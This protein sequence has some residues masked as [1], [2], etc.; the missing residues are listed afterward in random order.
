MFPRYYSH[1]AG[2]T[3]SLHLSP[4]LWEGGHGHPLL[5]PEFV[6]WLSA[7]SSCCSSMAMLPLRLHNDEQR[8]TRNL[9]G[10]MGGSC[11]AAWGGFPWCT[12][13]VTVLIQH[14]EDPWLCLA[15]EVCFDTLGKL[16]PNLVDH[17]CFIE[18]SPG[19]A[20]LP[21]A[22]QHILIPPT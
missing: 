8:G 11:S 16:T 18:P 4:D 7:L 22:P 13:T 3:T 9:Q 15:E 17:F 20:S 5:L 12:E 19:A 10:T 2:G 6:A 14:S 1:R 21:S